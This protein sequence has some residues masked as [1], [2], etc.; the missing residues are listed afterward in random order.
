MKFLEHEKSVLIKIPQYIEHCKW[1]KALFL[2]YETC[3]K[4]VLNTVFN[5]MLKVEGIDNFAAIISKHPKIQQPSIEFMKN[6]INDN[7]IEITTSNDEKKKLSLESFLTS[8][9][10]LED[11]LYYLL[12]RF[13]KSN[14]I[15]ERR[16][17]IKKA[18]QLINNKLINR[19]N[20]NYKFYK[21]YL[22]DLDNSLD[23]KVSC[24]DRKIGVI[25]KTDLN[26]FDNSLYDCFILGIKEDKYDWIENQ[27]KKTFEMGNKKL[28]YLK[29]KGFAEKGKFNLIEETIKKF[30]LKK[31]GLSPLIVA[32]LYMEYKEFDKAVEYINQTKDGQFFHYKIEMLKQME[33]YADALEVIISDKDYDKNIFMLNDILNKR[34]DLKQKANELFIK[35]NK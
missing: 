29:L 27:N 15:L 26:S 32:E 2:A 16:K 23:F 5:K 22:N 12:E 7:M 14:S 25:K 20:F 24:F 10:A 19:P 6:Y 21:N 18:K 30:T 34:P 8:L 11:Y 3:D 33:K 1:D 4:N 31:M 35:Y 17:L 9:K 13:F 28:S